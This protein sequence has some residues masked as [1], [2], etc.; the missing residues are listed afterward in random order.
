VL[1]ERGPD[2]VG[3]ERAEAGALARDDGGAHIELLPAGI[4]SDRLVSDGRWRLLER[5]R[6]QK[7]KVVDALSRHKNG[8]WLKRPEDLP[9]LLQVWLASNRCWLP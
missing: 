8:Q 7:Q 6:E 5:K 4:A 1:A 3:I 2:R 9:G